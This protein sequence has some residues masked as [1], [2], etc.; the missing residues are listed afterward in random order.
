MDST[1]NQRWFIVKTMNHFSLFI[2]RCVSCDRVLVNLFLCYF[3]FTS[4]LFSVSSPLLFDP[5]LINLWSLRWKCE[6]SLKVCGRTGVQILA[7]YSD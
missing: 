3:V 4:S 6:E 7:K 2:Q 5:R 1:L